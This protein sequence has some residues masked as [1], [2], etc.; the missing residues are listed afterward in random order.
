MATLSGLREYSVHD[1]RYLRE[2]GRQQFCERC[3]A[4]TVQE[5]ASHPVYALYATTGKK[6]ELPPALVDRFVQLHHE[7]WVVMHESVVSGMRESQSAKLHREYAR[8]LGT[9]KGDIFYRNLSR[10]SVLTLPRELVLLPDTVYQKIERL[11]E[12]THR[13]VEKRV[14][15][16]A[17]QRQG[18]IDSAPHAA[19]ELVEP[20]AAPL[21]VQVKLRNPHHTDKV[22]DFLRR[23]YRELLEADCKALESLFTSSDAFVDSG[24]AHRYLGAL[25]EKLRRV[26]ECRKGIERSL[27]CEV[28]SSSL[29]E[30]S[31][32]ALVAAP[33]IG[34]G[35][36]RHIVSPSWVETFDRALGEKE[37]F[38]SDALNYGKAFTSGVAK[39]P[40]YRTERI[41]RLDTAT[42]QELRRL[43]TQHRRDP[44]SQEFA[45]RGGVVYDTY[46]RASLER[47]LGEGNHLL[48][49]LALDGATSRIDGVFLFGRAGYIPKEVDDQ[50][51]ETLRDMSIPGSM[52]S[53]ADIMLLDKDRTP[54]AYQRLFVRHILAASLEGCQYNIGFVYETNTKHL[55]LLEASGAVVLHA[56]KSYC[57]STEP[58]ARMLNLPI[59]IDFDSYRVPGRS[60][61][62]A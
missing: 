31:E 24:A 43:I 19:I 20:V 11:C 28:M 59:L 5:L 55:R 2:I 30:G 62:K 8:T 3:A 40:H 12:G 16:S 4:L 1:L 48:V 22:R 25:G 32:Y 51:A 56:A 9:E 42:Y 44:A 61:S 37:R 50:V 58:R 57:E 54:G 14:I 18:Y 6:F 41:D 38:I 26:A 23:R 35:D 15:S 7:S 29:F 45:D 36:L 34:I 21:A 33:Q 47:Y 17:E 46:D 60:T 53:V 10:L 49:H 52:V 13:S 27:A 39:S